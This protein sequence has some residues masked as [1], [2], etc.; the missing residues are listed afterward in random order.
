MIARRGNR[1]AAALAA[2]ALLFVGAL[3]VVH[4]AATLERAVDGLVVVALLVALYVLRR[5]H[6]LRAAA[7]AASERAAKSDE[8]FRRSFEDA[9]S[10]LVVATLDGCVVR[11]NRAF[12]EL[13]G[14]SGDEL[15]GRRFADFT[16]PEDRDADVADLRRLIAGDIA[17]LRHEK[18]YLRPDGTVVWVELHCSLLRASDGGALNLTAQVLDISARKRAEDEARVSR[19]RIRALLDNLPDMTVATYDLDMRCDFIG[20]GLMATSAYDVD[21]ILGKT[22]HET[23][24]APVADQWAH[25]FRAALAGVPNTFH[26]GPGSDRELEIQILP[27][28][29]DGASVDSVMVVTR[30]VTERRRADEALRESRERLQAILDYAPAVIYVKDADGRF[31]LGNHG[32]EDLMGISFDQIRGQ[33]DDD[34]FDAETAAQ[35]REQDRQVRET[36]LPLAGEYELAAG[37]QVRTFF[38]IKFP[39]FDSRGNVTGVCAIATDITARKTAEIALRISEQRHRSVVEALDEGVLLYDSHGVVIACNQKA[40]DLVGLAPD[41]IVGQSAGDLPLRLVDEDGQEFAAE[42]RPGYRAILTGEPQ[43]DVIAGHP[44]PDGG[45]TWLSINAMPIADVGSDAPYA[46]ATSFA[47]ITERRRAERLKDEFFALV[48]HELRTPL[49]SITGYLE[50]LTD[51]DAEGQLDPSQRQF[52]G[53][54]E[55]NARR[56]QRLVGDLL[57]VAQFEAGKLSLDMDTVGLADVATEAIES[58]R[59]RATDLG[60]DLHLH[61]DDVPAVMGDAGRL[62]QTIDNLVSNALKFTPSGGRVEVRVTDGGDH[63]VIEVADTG[64]G[65]SREEQ[66]RLFERFFRTAIATEQA[67]P[68]VGLGLS[69]TKAIVEGH[70]GTITVASDEGRGTTFTI[71]LPYAGRSGGAGRLSGDGA[72]ARRSA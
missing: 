55:R 56:L 60:L 31:V 43:L 40:A 64:L 70:G 53:V 5:D 30:N 21:D 65:I 32:L 18:R 71:E 58:A 45:M 20:G 4:P 61:V 34:L 62:G 38:D 2:V 25:R 26:Q 28:A 19:R 22:L 7:R 42:E 68:G 69:I 50:L 15:L 47:D 8:L 44:R 67:I 57:F 49:T 33:T 46:V 35:T 51:D 23:L 14:F 37:G 72:T 63:A 10:G 52:L 59:P 36:E 6:L 12:C 16:H 29:G 9:A 1:V 48:S 66:K 54:V 11:A 39:I 24:G 41:A 17:Q 3:A 13:T 27:L